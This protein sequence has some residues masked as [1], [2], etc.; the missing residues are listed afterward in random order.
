MKDV[1][2]D[3]V[4]EKYMISKEDFKNYFCKRKIIEKKEYITYLKR[5]N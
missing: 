1:V 5:K 2:L 4:K 3:E